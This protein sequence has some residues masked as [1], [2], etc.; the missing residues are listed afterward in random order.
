MRENFISRT[1]DEESGAKVNLIDANKTL[2]IDQYTSDASEVP[3]LFQDAK[4]LQDVFD[5]FK[6]SVDVDFVTENGDTV[7]ETLQFNEMKD[8]DVDDGKGNLVMNCKFLSDIKVH[9]DGVAKVRKQ[10]EQ[11]AKLRALLKDQAARED[12][13]ALLKQMLDELENNK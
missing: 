4:T 2:M 12:L 10:I 11:N 6:P 5:H 7:S 9:G 3:E 1:E 13:K 8:F